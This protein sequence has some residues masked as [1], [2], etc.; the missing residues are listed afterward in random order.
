[1]VLFEKQPQWGEKQTPQTDLIL[2]YAKSLGLSTSKLLDDLHDQKIRDR[3]AQDKED[4]QNAGVT[5][6]PTFFVNGRMLG[7]LDETGLRELIDDEMTSNKKVA[8]NEEA[9]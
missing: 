7:E 3:I 5:G 8:E 6:T 9:K 4:G 1:M 2:S